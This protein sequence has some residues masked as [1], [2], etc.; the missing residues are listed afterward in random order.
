MMAKLGVLAV[1]AVVIVSHSKSVRP[2]I[3]LVG[4]ASVWIVLVGIP[5]IVVGI[6]VFVVAVLILA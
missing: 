5:I 1:L 3:V 4:F 6:V 2:T